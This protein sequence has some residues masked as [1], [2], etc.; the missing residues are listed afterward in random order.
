M[1]S[2]SE[3]KRLS[4]LAQKDALKAIEAKSLVEHE[5]NFKN[6]LKSVQPRLG[7]KA[8]APVPVPRRVLVDG[9]SSANK[10]MDDRMRS[11]SLDAIKHTV[12]TESHVAANVSRSGLREFRINEMKRQ[13]SQ[14]GSKFDFEL[15]LKPALRRHHDALQASENNERPYASDS[16][17]EAGVEI[18]AVL[19]SEE[20]LKLQSEWR[21]RDEEDLRSL[22]GEISGESHSLYSDSPS[23]VELK[24]ERDS[25]SETQPLLSRIARIREEILSQLD[26]ELFDRAYKELVSGMP[27][28]SV[29]SLLQGKHISVFVK[30]NQL[31]LCE[32]LLK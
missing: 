23:S 15:V 31:M 14:P 10:R 8:G 26:P 9:S 7:R 2:L 28:E 5:V 3:Q 6:R 29:M 4:Y 30:L 17:N 18:S 24:V 27:E 32:Q 20:M 11:S 16:E 25:A 19:P 13:A 12:P 22:V 21:E 1:S